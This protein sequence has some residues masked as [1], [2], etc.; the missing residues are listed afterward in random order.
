MGD[1]ILQYQLS[2]LHTLRMTNIITPGEWF[3]FSLG[4]TI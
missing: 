4:S 2:I 1:D 3:G